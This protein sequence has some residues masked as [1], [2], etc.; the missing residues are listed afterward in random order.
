VRKADVI[1]FLPSCLFLPRLTV[2]IPHRLV[3][4]KMIEAKGYLHGMTGTDEIAFL[5]EPS[6]TLSE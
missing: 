4:L 3:S 2:V 6:M 5:G 1:A